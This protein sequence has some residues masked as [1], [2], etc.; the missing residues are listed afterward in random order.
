MCH[1]VAKVTYL[2]MCRYIGLAL[3]WMTIEY[4][5]LGSICYY[6]FRIYFIYYF[7]NVPLECIYQIEEM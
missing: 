6:I 3:Y 1:Q 5:L 7:Q 4:L 2:I